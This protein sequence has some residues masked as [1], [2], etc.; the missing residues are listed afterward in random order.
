MLQTHPKWS[1]GGT[2]SLVDAL[3]IEGWTRSHEAKCAKDPRQYFAHQLG[4]EELGVSMFILQCTATKTRVEEY[5]HPLSKGF[6]PKEPIV[7]VIQSLSSWLL[8]QER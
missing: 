5:T 3:E 1:P 2:I 4:P 7:Q 6:Q 8:F